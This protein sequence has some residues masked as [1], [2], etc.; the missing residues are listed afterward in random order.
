MAAARQS[1]SRQELRAKGRGGGHFD[2][3]PN[4]ADPHG[5]VAY[6][7]GPRETDPPLGSF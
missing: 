1:G 2:A 3:A 6:R 5:L 4:S 7:S